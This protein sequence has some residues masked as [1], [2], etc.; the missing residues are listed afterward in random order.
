MAAHL[1]PASMPDMTVQHWL[2]H[3]RRSL[4]LHQDRRLVDEWPPTLPLQACRT[5]PPNIGS[6]TL[7]AAY[8]YIKIVSSWMNCPP[9][10]RKHGGHDRP[11]LAWARLPQLTAPTRFSA[12][13]RLPTLAPAKQVGHVRPTSATSRPSARARTACRTQPSSIGSATLAAASR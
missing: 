2:G 12:P 8:C 5:R 4:P 13:G 11:T 6:V 7:T 9:C 1:A 3:A 10:S